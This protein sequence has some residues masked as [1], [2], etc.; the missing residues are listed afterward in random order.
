LPIRGKKGE[1]VLFLN[2]EIKKELRKRGEKAILTQK[3]GSLQRKKDE[4]GGVPA[5]RNQLPLTK[6][7]E[8]PD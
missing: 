8:N 6:K 4:K 5:G 1:T 2:R 7:G 3:K